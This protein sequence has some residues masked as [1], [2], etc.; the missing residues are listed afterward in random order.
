MTAICAKL[1]ERNIYLLYLTC[2]E[3]IYHV[4][5]LLNNKLHTHISLDRLGLNVTHLY[6]ENN[7]RQRTVDIV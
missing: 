1:P 7:I 4:F 6:E 5:T 2:L 3:A